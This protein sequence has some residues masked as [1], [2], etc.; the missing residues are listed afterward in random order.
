MAI[1]HASRAI[2][3]GEGINFGQVTTSL[4]NELALKDTVR[5]LIA[6]ECLIVD[7]FSIVRNVH[8]WCMDWKTHLVP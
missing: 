7:G 3:V 1:S 5:V 4:K 8:V 6:F 2:S